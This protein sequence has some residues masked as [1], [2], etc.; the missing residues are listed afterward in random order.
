MSLNLQKDAWA[1]SI[2]LAARLHYEAECITVGLFP[3]VLMSKLQRGFI[4]TSYSWIWQSDI[5]WPSKHVFVQTLFPATL[6]QTVC[7][8]NGLALTK[9]MYQAHRRGG[10]YTKQQTFIQSFICRVLVPLSDSLRQLKDSLLSC[11]DKRKTWQTQ[12]LAV[13]AGMFGR[14]GSGSV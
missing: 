14:E 11:T 10:D 1:H 6:Y 8:E 9:T 13:L 12:K 2:H 5:F 7:K 4:D 3:K